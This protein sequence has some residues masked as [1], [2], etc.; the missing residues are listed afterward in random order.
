MPGLRMS[1]MTQVMPLCLGTSVSVR[2]SSS[3]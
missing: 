3:W 1:Q 2:T